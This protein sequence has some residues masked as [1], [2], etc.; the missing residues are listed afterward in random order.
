[1]G[2]YLKLAL[3]AKYKSQAEL[4]RINDELIEQFGAVSRLWYDRVVFPTQRF[5]V[6]E[7]EYIN[8]APEGQ[9]QCPYIPRPVTVN[10]LI[11]AHP[12]SFD[13]GFIQIKLNACNEE[14]ARMARAVAIWSELNA[15]K[16]KTNRS[17]NYDR[18]T[19]FQ[20]TAHYF[21]DKN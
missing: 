8:N 3:R 17:D 9:T 4:D 12:E 15:E 2:R 16:I 1:M 11:Q 5:A 6:L 21:E 7:A 14:E 13:I 19:V 20:Y 10:K 18:A